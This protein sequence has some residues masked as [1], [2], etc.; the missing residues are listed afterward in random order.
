MYSCKIW[1]NSK[2]P[3]QTKGDTGE[4][5][6]SSPLANYPLSKEEEAEL[7]VRGHL[8]QEDNT[9]YYE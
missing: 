5:R 1:Q 9:W 2:I 3:N 8:S 4:K 7:E 6:D